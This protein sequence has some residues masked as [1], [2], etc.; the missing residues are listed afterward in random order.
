MSAIFRAA[1]GSVCALALALPAAADDAGLRTRLDAALKHRGLIGATIGALVVDASDGRVVYSREPDTA[2]VPASNVKILTALAV[3]ASFGP[4]HRFETS[5]YADR[6]PDAQGQVGTLYLRGGGDPSLTSED[7][8]RLAADLRRAGL[9]GVT[10]GVVVDASLFDGEKWH[11]TW[12]RVSSRA[13][14]APVS[15]F[16]ANYGAFAVRVSPGA[17]VGDPVQVVLDPPVPTLRLV[18]RA[19]TVS[20]R[21]RVSLQV[22]R[23]AGEGV[24]DVIVSGGL[25][26]GASPKTHYRSVSDPERYA[27]AVLRMQ[28][29]A[30]GI[31]VPAKLRRAPVPEAAVPLARFEGK[32]MSEI[33][34]LFMKYS[35]NV[36]GESLVKALAAR[37]GVQPAGWQPGI[38]AIRKELDA[39]GVPLGDAIQVDGSGLS[40]A[41]RIAPRAFVTALQVAERSFRF[42]PEFVASLPI[43]AADGT[44]AE[45]AERTPFGVR[46]KTGS[47]TRVTSLSG[48]ADG[49]DG[50]R[51]VFSLLVN[52]FK[53]GTEDAWQG[54]DRFLEAMVEPDRV[55]VLR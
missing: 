53:R 36:I 43:A 12:G 15:S 10:E 13:Y 41:N 55:A 40:Y 28:L 38:E 44:L 24:E 52:G 26:A 18:N 17:A 27:V 30:N 48:Y 6:A 35:N 20:R 16:A 3:L 39:L 46:A 14:N 50:R 23:R 4:A 29:E 9:R 54:V 22:D 45:R 21:S 1:M 51:F 8:W 34:R 11:P 5:V 37:A 33:V 25:R 19:K 31:A 32:S 7:Y 42:G 2:L 47:L 49:H